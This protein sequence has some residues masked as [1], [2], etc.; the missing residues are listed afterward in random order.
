MTS[1]A[2]KGIPENV[3]V[4]SFSLKSEHAWQWQYSVIVATVPK[5]SGQGWILV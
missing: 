5:V 3:D 1:P 2:Q 4:W